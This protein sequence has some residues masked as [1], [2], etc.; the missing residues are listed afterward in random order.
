MQ[1][2]QKDGCFQMLWGWH[3]TVEVWRRLG[4]N[5]WCGSSFLNAWI[6]RTCYVWFGC[7]PVSDTQRVMCSDNSES[8]ERPFFSCPVAWM[9]W[10]NCL[11]WWGIKWCYQNS[12]MEFFEA[13]EGAP[14]RGIEK[15]LWMSMMYVVL[16]TI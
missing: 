1:K 2:P 3:N 12:T 10:Y 11:K 7:I 16:W 15:K 6:Q 9:L 8:I 5:F 13:W 4:W 14:C